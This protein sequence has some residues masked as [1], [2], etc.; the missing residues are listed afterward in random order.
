MQL[1]K[2]QNSTGSSAYT[3]MFNRNVRIRIDLIRAPQPATRPTRSHQAKRKFQEGD[4][5]QIRDYSD[6]KLKWVFG[7]VKKKEGILHYTILLNNGT[8]CR[9]HVDQ[10][11]A[12]KFRGED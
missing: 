4:H 3:L 6:H 8:T 10:I 12:T 7:V 11:R 2:V 1:R 5:V 9:R